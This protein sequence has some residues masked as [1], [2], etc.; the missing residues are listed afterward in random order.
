MVGIPFTVD[1][2]DTEEPA[3]EPGEFPGDY[4]RRMARQKGETVLRR[5]EDGSLVLAAD[6]VVYFQKKILGK[7]RSPEEAAEMLTALAGQTHTV[8]T[9]VV[10]LRSL[11]PVREEHTFSEATEVEFYPMTAAEIW[12]YVDSGEPMDKAGAYGIQGPFAA[13]VK[14]IKGDFYNVVGLPIARTLQFLSGLGLDPRLE[15]FEI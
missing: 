14:G 3:P 2:A 10:L 1:P 5:H 8:V 7:P 4:A 6:T 12:R 11:P 13:Y 15:T 9:S